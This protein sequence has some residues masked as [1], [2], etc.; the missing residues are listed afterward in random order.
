MLQHQ[1]RVCE[2]HEPPQASCK[3]KVDC[4]WEEVANM[5]RADQVM[6]WNKDDASYTG[7]FSDSGIEQGA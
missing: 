4:L 3:G 5:R 7:S 6:V 2:A 1:H